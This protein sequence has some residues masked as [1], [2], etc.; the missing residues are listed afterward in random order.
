M[1]I[2]PK[3]KSKTCTRCKVR[4]LKILNVFPSHGCRMLL[5][6]PEQTLRKMK[7]FNEGI[8]CGRENPCQLFVPSFLKKKYLP[9]NTEEAR[10]LS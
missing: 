3:F 5:R 7:F 4:Y 9:F 2:K 8:K 10:P 1:I 6:F